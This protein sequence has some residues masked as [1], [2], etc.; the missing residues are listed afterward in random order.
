MSVK[1][2]FIRTNGSGAYTYQRPFRGVIHGIEIKIGT[3]STPD[4]AITDDTYSKTILSVTG[5]AADTR[6]TPSVNLQTSAGASA[7]VSDESGVNVQALGPAICMGDLKIAVT[8]AGNG[9]SGEVVI[10]YS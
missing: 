5:V 7:D 8:G 10:L 9:T 4:V 2:I 6:Y 1:R 3:L